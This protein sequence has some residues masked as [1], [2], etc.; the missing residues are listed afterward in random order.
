MPQEK[1]TAARPAVRVSRFY[2]DCQSLSG[3]GYLLPVEATE[4]M[5]MG[6]VARLREPHEVG[7]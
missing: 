4:A 6:L 3:L 1:G 7:C 2:L 5:T